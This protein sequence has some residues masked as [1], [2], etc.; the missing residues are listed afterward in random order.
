MERLSKEGLEA[1][2]GHVHQ[3]PPSLGDRRRVESGQFLSDQALL[4]A[5]EEE[6]TGPRTIMLQVCDRNGEWVIPGKLGCQVQEESQSGPLFGSP[7]PADQLGEPQSITI[8]PEHDRECPRDG[9]VRV[10]EAKAVDDH[11]LRVG[12]SSV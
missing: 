3:E 4:G 2:E 7:C 1:I 8:L 12:G 11:L 5:F 6:N 10:S 9:R